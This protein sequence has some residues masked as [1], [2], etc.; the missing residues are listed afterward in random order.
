MVLRRPFVLSDLVCS[1]R[2]DAVSGPY[3]SR[4][5]LLHTQT[6][7]EIAAFSIMSARIQL[8]PLPVAKRP[9]SQWIYSGM[10]LKHALLVQESSGALD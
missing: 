6:L 8:I 10:L 2:I 7:F 1:P 9:P 4:R 3:T 5:P